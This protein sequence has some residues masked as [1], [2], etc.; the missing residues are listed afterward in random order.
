MLAA[1][2]RL[3]LA[4]PRRVLLA[5]V[6][7][8]GLGVFAL[9]NG[10]YDVF[11]D[12]VPPEAEV[13]TEAPGMVSQQVEELITRPIEQAIAGTAGVESVRSESIAGLSVIR[14]V[15][16]DGSD[17]F[18]DRQ[19][20]AE[21]LTEVTGQLPLG[22]GTP[23]LGPMTSSTMDLLKVGL[24][25]DK[26]TPAQLRT[27]ADWTVRQRLQSVPGV[28][29]VHVFGGEVRELQVDVDA[30]RLTALG[31]SL[32]E[33]R[34]SATDALGQYGAGF[35]E[36]DNQRILVQGAGTAL[37]PDTL[38]RTLITRHAGRNI[39]LADVANIH[40][41][42]APAYGD[43]LIQGQ[44]GVLLALL[45]QPDA[46]TLELTRSVEAAL[47]ELKPML[48][49]QG[50]ALTPATHRPATFIEIALANLRNSLLLGAALVLA[51][52]LLFL[53]NLR[54]ALISFLSIPLSLLVAIWVM[55]RMGWTLN[56][57]TLGG[58]AV[59]VGLVVDDAIIDVENIV[60][61]LRHLPAA[62]PLQERIAVVAS[63]SLE[64]RRP[65]VL[66]TFIVGAV[67]L[68]VLMLSGLQGSFF[69]P[70]AAAFLLAT[71]ASL[72][73]AVTV[74]PA[75][76]LLL[77]KP[78]ELQ[79][80]PRWLRRVKLCQHAALRRCLPHTRALL[81]V[82]LLAGVAALGGFWRFGSQLLPAFREGHFVIP[83]TTQSGTAL[84]EMMRSGAALSHAI[85]AIDGVQSVSEQAGRASNGEDTW[86][87]EQAELHVELKPGLSGSAQQRIE[88]QLHAVLVAQPGLRFEILT[89]LGD[90]I[91]ESLGGEAAPVSVSLYGNDLDRLDALAAQAS[92][93]LR[94]LPDA[95]EVVSSAT[96]QVPTLRIQADAQRLG[97]LGLRPA[98]VLGAVQ[99]A[100]QGSVVGQVYEGATAI[101]TRVRLDATARSEPE[102]LGQLPLQSLAGRSVPLGAVADIDLLGSRASILHADGRRRQV[103]D[104]VPTTRDYSGFATRARALLEFRLQLPAG[105]YF[106]FGGAGEGARAAQRELLWHALLAAALILALLASAFPDRRRILLILANLPFAIAGGVLMVALSG[107]LL[108][109]GTLVGFVTLFGI[110]ARNTILLLAHYD[111]LQQIEARR[112]SSALALRG[113][114]ERLAPILMTALV[115][116]LGLLPLALGSGE[117]GREIEAPMAQVILGGLLTSTLLNLLL[118]PLLAARFLKSPE[119]SAG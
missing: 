8:L 35:I 60:R 96:A 110:C 24:L 117:A 89:F 95:G 70:L 78:G 17:L 1:I 90:R 106:E 62:A 64:V 39:Q 30:A 40:W 107:G 33:V 85:L 23:M 81:I 105:Y 71:F 86:P 61:R 116:A 20:L 66:A 16:S 21:R 43:A 102:L 50:V 44:R 15:F 57:M 34:S 93:L 74:T 48:Q 119:P 3:V 55:Q 69:A 113:A 9:I 49:A 82:A 28:A 109:I 67:F 47:A 56:T 75:L 58:L 104:I 118:M 68:P 4:A 31:L 42:A 13:Q 87:P 91:G 2:L 6:L 73:V 112:W 51:V 14:V 52:L 79:R 22:S 72:I 19:L 115:T 37:D 63:A 54:T 41:G 46:N 29:A 83:I 111:H 65:I 53:R 36:N 92:T 7:V 84:P 99:L 32:D 77:L 114:R 38:G 27:L 97:A 26:L 88:A 100:N 59:A 80:E 94:S 76:C 5:A 103:I 18:R 98:E 25:S 45:S 108:S 10:R 101:D 11:P 12:F